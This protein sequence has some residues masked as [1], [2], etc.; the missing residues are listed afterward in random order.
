MRI[1]FDHLGLKG[2]YEKAVRY[3]HEFGL[4]ELSNY[5]LY[6]FHDNPAD[7]FERM[8]LNVFLNEELE[9][10]IWSFPMRY[11]P[12]NRPDRGFIGEKWTRFQLRSLQIVLQATH[13]VVSGAPE[14][15]KRAFGDTFEQFEN[16]LLRPHHFIFNR[17][18]YE[19]FGGRAEFDEYQALVSKL[20]AIERAQL[21]AALSSRD[22]SR[23]S[24]LVAA[25]T[26]PRVKAVLRFYLPISKEAER[27][28]WNVQKHLANAATDDCGMPDEDRI[29]DAGL[30]DDMDAV[31]IQPSDL[32]A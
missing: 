6:N 27:E 17:E 10:R 12:T 20:D 9:V 31:N 4:H 5:M 8:R 29:E 16:I 28:I 1:A 2:P 14:F 18:W 25:E 23:Y 15:F 32:A 26:D 19:F 30:H 11:Q 7:L 3:A 24:E 21:L 22:P 13:G